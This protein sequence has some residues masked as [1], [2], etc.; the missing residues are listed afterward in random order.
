MAE[1]EDRHVLMFGSNNYLGLTDHPQVVSAAHDALEQYGTSCTGSRFV[2]GSLNLH[3]DLETDLATF[4]GKEAALV[5]TT[6]C[7]TN[8]GSIAAAGDPR[9]HASIRRAAPR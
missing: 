7:Q 5:F 1:V 3:R 9:A 4:F 2:N 6:G 8:L